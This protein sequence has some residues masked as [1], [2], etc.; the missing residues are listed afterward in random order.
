MM[1]KVLSRPPEKQ[2]LTVVL[3]NYEKS[4]IK[5]SIE[6]HFS[7]EKHSMLLNFVDLSTIF[8]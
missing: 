7:I 1:G 5:H 4:A 3:N 8:C 6:K 2:I